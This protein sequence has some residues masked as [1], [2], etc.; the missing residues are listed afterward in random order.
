M[1]GL[2]QEASP[3]CSKPNPEE[4]VASQ[5]GFELLQRKNTN[6]MR[7]IIHKLREQP[8]VQIV[9]RAVEL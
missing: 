5:L 4:C 7:P 1:V 6:L 2:S 8:P 3:T 9:G